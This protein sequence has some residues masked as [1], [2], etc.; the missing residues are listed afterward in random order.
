MPPNVQFAF[1]CVWVAVQVTVN[2][3][4]LMRGPPV[5]TSADSSNPLPVAVDV[6]V[7]A[8]VFGSV[9]VVV[10]DDVPPPKVI[11]GFD[12]CWAVVLVGPPTEQW[13]CIGTLIVVPAF[14]NSAEPMFAT[15]GCGD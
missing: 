14:V 5:L 9:T 6:V 1:V 2:V 10:Q 13:P 4:S 3:D 15:P 7:V 8:L 11:P 12:T